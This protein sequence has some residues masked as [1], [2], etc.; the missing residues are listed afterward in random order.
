V[1]NKQNSFLNGEWGGHVRKGI[2]KITSG[3]RRMEDKRVIKAEESDFFAI[4]TQPFIPHEI[5]KK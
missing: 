1:G 4:E 5:Y 3:K 2:K